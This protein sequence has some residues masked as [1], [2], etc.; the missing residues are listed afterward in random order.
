MHETTPKK[1]K[2]SDV[3][4]FKIFFLV[5]NCTVNETQ[6]HINVLLCDVDFDKL[7]IDVFA[8][9]LSFIVFCPEGGAKVFWN[10]VYAVFVVCIGRYTA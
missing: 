5:V 10:P 1:Q 4:I 2:Y 9:F 3:K 6:K 8:F 7:S